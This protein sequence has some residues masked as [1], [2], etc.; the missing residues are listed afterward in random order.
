MLF[1]GRLAYL[2]YVM[3][4]RPTQD[5]IVR[6][7]ESYDTAIRDM[8]EYSD[9]KNVIVDIPLADCKAFLVNVNSSGLLS[10]YYHFHFTS[11][12]RHTFQKSHLFIL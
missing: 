6:L 4:S 7:L 10:G 11:L 3:G 12:V 1:T 2:K 5:V 8:I 9:Y